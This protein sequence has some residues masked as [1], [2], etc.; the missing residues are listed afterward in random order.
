ML[1]GGILT[2][3]LDQVGPNWERRD[4]ANVST[5]KSIIRSAAP[6]RKIPVSFWRVKNKIHEWMGPTCRSGQ[7]SSQWERRHIVGSNRRV[8]PDYG[9]W[10]LCTHYPFI[11]SYSWWHLVKAITFR[12][13]H[14]SHNLISFLLKISTMEVHDDPWS[15]LDLN[16]LKDA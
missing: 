9:E 13:W 15:Y 14:F 6:L 12:W 16:I 11:S 1:L 8:S 3:R 7:S 10:L 5:C 4:I 2:R